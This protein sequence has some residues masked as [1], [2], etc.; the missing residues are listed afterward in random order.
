MGKYFK[1]GDGVN[2]F[3]SIA[4]ILVGDYFRGLSI[5]YKYFLYLSKFLSLHSN[6]IEIL[7]FWENFY[8]IFFISKATCFNNYLGFEIFR[9]SVANPHIDLDIKSGS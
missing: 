8:V 1:Q 5:I 2:Y 7:F 6:N 4:S 3:S 9:I